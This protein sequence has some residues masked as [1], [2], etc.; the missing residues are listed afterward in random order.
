[1]LPSCTC[2]A[3]ATPARH[4]NMLSLVWQAVLEGQ[5]AL[6]LEQGAG[7]GSL[8][9]HHFAG[10]PA[11]SVRLQRRVTVW[12][13]CR[14]WPACGGGRGEPG[15]V[16]SCRLGA[17]GPAAAL[18]ATCRRLLDLKAAGWRH[19]GCTL[20]SGRQCTCWV[21][22]CCRLRR[23][24]LTERRSGAPAASR[25]L[26]CAGR[27]CARERRHAAGKPLTRVAARSSK[28]A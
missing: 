6:Q 27:C 9:C 24:L 28:G 4:G 11:G 17:P 12:G 26:A 14:G 25:L 3:R 20:A 1:M 19:E 2:P 13:V 8:R 5:D 16:A 22:S 7:L 15:Y 10:L 18:A 21:R 23:C